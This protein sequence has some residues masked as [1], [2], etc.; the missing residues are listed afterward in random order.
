MLVQFLI[1]LALLLLNGLFAMA[2]LAVVS[3]RRIRLKQMAE[4]GSKGDPLLAWEPVL[5]SPGATDSPANGSMVAQIQ[6]GL[7]DLVAP[8][9]SLEALESSDVHDLAKQLETVNRLMSAGEVEDAGR[10][11]D[12]D[13]AASRATLRATGSPGDRA[14]R[15]SRGAR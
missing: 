1:L 14:A 2:E 4:Q 9:T 10:R 7:D 12:D 13:R 11:I 3:S 8:D 5:P 15:R 6:R